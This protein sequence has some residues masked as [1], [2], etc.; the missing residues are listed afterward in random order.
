M[1]IHSAIQTAFIIAILAL[2]LSFWLGVRSIRGAR[3]LK[4]F[5]MRRD[6][7][8]RGW[9]L[10]FFS[11]T[12]VLLS[13]F[14]RGYAEPVIYHFYPPTATLTMTP[15]LTLT[16]TITK[17]PTVTLTP[18]ITPTP[19]V[20]DTPTA[21]PTP[22]VPLAVEAQFTSTVTP[23]P[24]AIFSPLV[25]A[26]SVNKEYQP[27]NPNTTFKNPVGHMYAVFSYDKMAVGAQWT[28]IW[29]RNGELVYFETKPW[30]G[31]VGGFGYTDWNPAPSEWLPGAYEVQIFVGLEWKL[32]GTFTVEGE[33]PTAVATKT[34]ALSQT[35]QI[36]PTLAG[37]G[38]SGPTDTLQP[39]QATPSSTPTPVPAA[40]SSTPTLRS[41]FTPTI[42]ATHAPTFTPSPALPTNTKAPT[43][44]EIP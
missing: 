18:T 36:T 5:R 42:P 8:V 31:A 14:L 12:M 41:T 19:S 7:M 38:T 6:R 15:T 20:T 32:S 9:R 33:A 34:P 29:Y 11:L 23:N 13:F 39:R 22:H 43:A 44:T 2:L 24:A 26:Q 28:S 37:P 1:D 4:F 21:T 27:V 3:D 17:T 30:D 10:V 40:P 16:P 25:F 35:A